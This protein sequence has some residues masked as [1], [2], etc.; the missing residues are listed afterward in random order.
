[1]QTTAYIFFLCDDSGSM[2]PHGKIQ[3]LNQAV[4][5]SLPLLKTMATSLLDT[6][7]YVQALTFNSNF[8]H[9]LQSPIKLMDFEWQDLQANGLSAA[10]Q[11]FNQLQNYIKNTIENYR[12]C[13]YCFILFTDGFPS[14]NYSESLAKFH[15]FVSNFNSISLSVAIGEDC[16]YELLSNF[17]RNNNQIKNIF[18]AAETSSIAYS[19]PWLTSS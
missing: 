13:N 4:R 10:G 11:T 12:T 8:N 6:S 15:K 5:Q 14:D 3:S 19:I 9:V 1:M 2:A 18:A 7:V 17:A 16:E